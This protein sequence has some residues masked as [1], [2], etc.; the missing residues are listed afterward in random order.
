[1]DPNAAYK[2]W[3]EAMDEEAAK[4]AA[5]NLLQWLRRG[6]F[7]PSWGWAEKEGFFRWCAHYKVG[8]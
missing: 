8:S 5:S 3:K 4:V 2:D 1:M 7:E 6:G